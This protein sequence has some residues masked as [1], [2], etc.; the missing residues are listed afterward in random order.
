MKLQ[1]SNIHKSFSDIPILKGITFSVQSGEAMGF[2]GRNGAGKTTTLRALMGVFHQDKGEF[3]V[4]GRPF[5]PGEH[6]V[7]YLPEERGLYPK[8][9]IEDQLVY[10]GRL[11]GGDKTEL[12]KNVEYWLDRVQLS[13]YRKKNLETLSKG[14]QQKIQIIQTLMND[15]DIIILD[16]PFSGL[17][18][19]NSMILKDII[20]DL[21]A[22]KK[23]VI[24]SS[25]QM[26]YVEEFCDEI[27]LIDQG[28]IIL[29]GNLTKIK[30]EKGKNRIRIASANS[31]AEIT[32][33]LHT[34]GLVEIQ[35]DA[36]S[37]ILSL[38]AGTNHQ[39]ALQQLLAKNI[40]IISFS[41]YL[42][43]LTDIFVETV[44]EL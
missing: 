21:I 35:R 41:P 28:E 30:R 2:L 31:S 13:Q 25:H 44:G 14:N 6:K 37:Y 12:L 11:R 10:F 22:Q 4:D 33:A 40:D 24:F 17:D 15:P 8:E 19:V 27:T 38:P 36:Q 32:N 7:G 26:N 3:L 9:S 39:I 5:V 20:L 34:F 1:I 18:P 43:N 29:S 23:L 16:E 42:P